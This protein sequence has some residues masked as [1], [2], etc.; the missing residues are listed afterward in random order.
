LAAFG[1][2]LVQVLNADAATARL[3][4]VGQVAE[5]VEVMEHVVLGHLNQQ[6][7][8]EFSL[9]LQELEQRIAKTEV[10]HGLG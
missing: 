4:C 9:A 5:S 2:A 7:F 8:A 10:G 6:A 3:E 1:K